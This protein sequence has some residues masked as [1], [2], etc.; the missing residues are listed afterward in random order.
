MQRLVP[1]LFIGCLLAL[2]AVA[3]RGGGHGGGG[4]FRGGMGGGFRGGM[5]GGFRGGGFVG[6]GFRGG[7]GGFRGGGFRGGFVGFRGGFRG[8]FPRNRVFVGYG[9]SPWGYWPNY[10]GYPYYSAGW[11]YPYYGYSN[12]D[13]SGYSYPPYDY[14]SSPSPSVVIYRSQPTVVYDAQAQQEILEYP[15]TSQG[16]GRPIYLIALKGQ[17]NVYAAQAYWVSQNSL[18]FVTL[19]GEQ[20]QAPVSSVD[21]AL[22]FRLNDD[23]HVDFWLPADR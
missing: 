9:F 19:Q 6:P 16:N 1:S 2:P 5:G 23:R 7:F 13:Y 20:K 21:R 10:W 11:G 22:T 15:E 4:G 17:N 8:F 12:Y 14:G 18:H 3:Q